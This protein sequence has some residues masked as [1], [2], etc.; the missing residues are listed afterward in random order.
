LAL[1]ILF[2]IALCDGGLPSFTWDP[3]ETTEN[4]VPLLHVRFADGGPDDVILLERVNPIPVTDRE[5]VAVN[6]CIF[7]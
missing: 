3:V 7:R 2:G 4:G 1:P 6:Q 5:T